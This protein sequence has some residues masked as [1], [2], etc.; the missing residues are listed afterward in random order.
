MRVHLEPGGV[1]VLDYEEQYRGED[2]WQ[3]WL[4]EKGPTLPEPAAAPHLHPSADGA[5]IGLRARL[6]DVAE[7]GRE[8]VRLTP[9]VDWCAEVR[10]ESH[11]PDCPVPLP[12]GPDESTLL[13]TEAAR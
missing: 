1:L 6:V 7:D 10:G 9:A 3:R 2:E 5:E 13:P 11:L 12:A 4:A 8:T